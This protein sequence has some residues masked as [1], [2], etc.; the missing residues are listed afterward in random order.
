MT[1]AFAEASHDCL[2]R[3]LHGTWFGHTSGPRKVR[4]QDAPNC[5]QRL[6]V[7]GVQEHL[8]R[9]LVQPL[10]IADTPS[11]THGVLAHAP[12]ALEGIAVVATMGWEAV[13]A[14]CAGG[15]VECRV[16]LV[17]PMDS[18]PGDDHHDLVLGGPAGRHHRVDGVAQVLRITV[19]HDFIADFRGAIL[20]SAEDGQHDPAALRSRREAASSPGVCAR[21]P[22]SC[23][24]DSTAGWAGDSGGGSAPP[25]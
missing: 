13:E 9:A 17:C 6:A 4:A 1:E 21:L 19:G 24:R 25:R 7:L 3:M 5:M 10:H 8:A 12:T 15:V 11:P 23:G 2:T 16:A 18:A 22:V 20:Y 14:Q